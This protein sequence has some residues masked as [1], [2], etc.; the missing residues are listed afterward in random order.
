MLKSQFF[1][2]HV[3]LPLFLTYYTDDYRHRAEF[4][5]RA[6]TVPVQIAADKDCD[7]H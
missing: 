7:Q 6:A 5:V 3:L 4:V 1:V 2:F